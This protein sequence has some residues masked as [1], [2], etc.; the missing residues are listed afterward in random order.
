MHFN[1]NTEWQTYFDQ[2]DIG[3]Y[4]IEVLIK[5]PRGTSFRCLVFGITQPTNSSPCMNR[6]WFGQVL[7]PVIWSGDRV[8]PD[9]PA[10]PARFPPLTCRRSWQEVT[11]MAK[12]TSNQLFTEWPSKISERHSFRRSLLEYQRLIQKL[13]SYQTRRMNSKLL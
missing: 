11:R 5:D 6:F 7:D 4:V 2:G 9:K 1:L 12:K 8:A 13:S 10:T 3:E